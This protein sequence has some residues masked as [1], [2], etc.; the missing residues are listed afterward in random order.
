MT[1]MNPF[2]KHVALPAL[3][4][5]AV[6]GLYFTPIVLFGCVNRGLM[7]ITVVLVSTAAA[8]VA[9]AIGVRARAQNHPSSGRWL[10]STLILL[11]PIA[12]VVGPL[13]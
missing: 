3:A 2:I 8:C 12:L 5:A 13:G 7:A 6:V 4:P 9:T 1:N 10:L 11:L